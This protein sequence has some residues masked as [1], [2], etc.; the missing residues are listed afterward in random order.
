MHRNIDVIHNNNIVCKLREND[1]FPYPVEFTCVSEGSSYWRV[2]LANPK[3]TI[4]GAQALDK[5]K[6]LLEYQKYKKGP[7]YKFSPHR[8]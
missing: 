2:K 6:T 5:D 7:K 1:T 8:Y 3:V 4:P